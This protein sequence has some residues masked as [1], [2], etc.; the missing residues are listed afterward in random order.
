MVFVSASAL[1]AQDTLNSAV[2]KAFFEYAD[3]SDMI[4]YRPA[5]ALRFFDKS[6]GDVVGWYW[7]FGDGYTSNEQNPF[8]VYRH[9]YI[10]DSTLVV[11]NPYCTV[12]LTIV[13]ADGC[14]STYTE[15]I[16]LSG[17][18]PA[19][20]SNC[21][22]RFKY[23]V[24]GIDL[25]QGLATIQFNSRSEGK[26]LQYGWYFDGLGT[27]SESD[28]VFVFD[29][30]QRERKICLTITGADS[31]SDQFCDAVYINDPEINPIDT[32]N[33]GCYTGFGYS[34]NLN[35]QTFAPALVL[36]FYFKSSD[37][38]EKVLWDFGDGT[39]S[40]QLNPTHIFYLPLNNDS[41][42]FKEDWLRTVCLTV[43]TVSGCEANYCEVIYLYDNHSD[44]DPQDLNCQAGFKYYVPFDVMTAPEVK[45]FVLTDASVG[46]VESR[47]W[48]FEDGTT[49][50]EKEFMITFDIFKPTQKVCLTINT[51]DGCT[52]TWC[53]VLQVATNVN[54]DQSDSMCNYDLVLKGEFPIWASS[55]AGKVSAFLL[56]GDSIVPDVKFIW[57][58]GD[59]GSELKRV[60]PTRHLS[61]T[62][63]TPDGCKLTSMFVLNSDGSVDE[64]PIRWW[65]TNKENTSRI[66]Y[67]VSDKSYTVE[68]ILCDGTI[69]YRN[70]VPVDLVNCG[71]NA[72]N[73]VLKD[74]LGNI[75]YSEIVML[76][77]PTSVATNINTNDQIKFFPIPV[78]DKLMVEYQSKPG[79]TFIV[80]LHD[81]S[82]RSVIRHEL[83][84]GAS[85]SSGSIDVSHLQKGIY[86]AKVYLGNELIATKKLIK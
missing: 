81:L 46:K 51:T 69:I 23:Y 9:Q 68:W 13:T 18:D 39:T 78:K 70:D 77:A 22:S 2:C 59:V 11:I 86:V 37:Q 34:V 57:S 64:V 38:V 63:Y 20:P 79:K 1:Y 17:N 6:E 53:D 5:T 44:Q 74:E 85:A 50:E 28:P 25:E 14:K 32:L 19:D 15:T 80:E 16:K 40:D 10:N 82:G 41:A 54:D 29:L 84:P 30:S 67:A 4:S 56:L 45:P 43:T 66:Q 49:S 7:E 33:Q 42:F 61:V 12:T 72:P 58:T 62:A 52:S 65:I 31:C 73:L 75:V 26:E 76:S 71:G 35:V 55:C 83:K 3:H 8:H 36:D 47:L 48:Q 24:A 27:S 21:L 60:C